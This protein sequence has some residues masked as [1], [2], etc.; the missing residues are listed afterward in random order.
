ME[1]FFIISF[2]IS[3]ILMPWLCKKYRGRNHK[4]LYLFFSTVLSPFIGYPLYRL[5]LRQS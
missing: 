4:V 2:T 3:L 1:L 5:M